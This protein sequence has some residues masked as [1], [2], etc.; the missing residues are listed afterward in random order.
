MPDQHLSSCTFVS[1]FCQGPR[2]VQREHKTIYDS[3]N[4]N[5]VFFSHDVVVGNAEGIWFR[6][7]IGKIDY[8]EF[9]LVLERE[10]LILLREKENSF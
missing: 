3:N 4:C 5:L 9:C 1:G 2:D 10:L 8:L 6:V 7:H